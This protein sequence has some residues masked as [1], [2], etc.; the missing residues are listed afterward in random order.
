MQCSVSKRP[1]SND[2][3]T[4]IR[5]RNEQ[6]PGV[7]LA[8]HK[9]KVSRCILPEAGIYELEGGARLY[10]THLL[11]PNLCRGIR[12][13]ALLELHNIHVMNRT[14]TY[15]SIYCCHL[16]TVRVVQFSQLSS[17]FT[18]F[19]SCANKVTSLVMPFRAKDM[20]CLMEMLLMFRDKFQAN[21]RW[22]LR[23]SLKI[24]QALSKR[25]VPHNIVKSYFLME[26]P[27]KCP[28]VEDIDVTR[29]HVWTIQSLIEHVTNVVERDDFHWQY[30]HC[31][32]EEQAVGSCQMLCS[33]AKWKYGIVDCSSDTVGFIIACIICLPQHYHLLM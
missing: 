9:G 30:S 29:L 22:D 12:Q 10:L 19:C 20:I 11:C 18:P 25:F 24:L 13:G 5:L 8:F 17:R 33:S 32:F 28:A 31:E 27:H 6:V 21:G 14:L 1:R 3:N 23:T 4:D 16:S 26:E 7:A 2:S 15:P